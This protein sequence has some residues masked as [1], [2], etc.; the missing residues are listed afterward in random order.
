[1]SSS[2]FGHTTDMTTS[3]D[4]FTRE[5]EDGY[6]PAHPRQARCRSAKCPIRRLGRSIEHRGLLQR[7]RIVSHRPAV[8]RLNIAND[9]HARI[10]WPF[11]SSP[12]R[13]NSRRACKPLAAISTA[14]ARPRQNVNRPR[15][16]IDHRRWRNPNARLNERAHYVLRWRRSQAAPRLQESCLPKWRASAVRIESVN[17]LPNRRAFTFAPVRALSA[18]EVS[19]R[20]QRNRP[21]SR[22]KENKSSQHY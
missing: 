20:A 4:C 16:R 19:T 10:A 7:T 12:A 3:A 14:L 18:C 21:A 9:A 17:T 15:P 8:I 22:H 5:T 11:G 2:V 6:C 1:M 13:G